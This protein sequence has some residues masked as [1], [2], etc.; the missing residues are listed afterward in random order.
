M[1][2]K[3][4]I[5]Y[6]SGDLSVN[7]ISKISKIGLSTINSALDELCKSKIFRKVMK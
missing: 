1:A 4:L 6:S 3:W 7:Q 5:H 2:I